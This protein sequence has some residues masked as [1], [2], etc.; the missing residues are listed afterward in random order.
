MKTV[1]ALALLGA[2]LAPAKN[3]ARP[4]WTLAQAKAVLTQSAFSVT[5]ETQ[6][7]RPE[8]GLTFN[9]HALV[10]C[11]SSA[12][13]VF[14]GSAH[15]AF[16]DSDVPRALHV[17]PPGPHHAFPWT[18]RGH[19][20]A[21]VPD[22]RR[23]LLRVVS[24]GV[25]PRSGPS[26]QPAST[27]RSTTTATPTRGRARAHRR[28]ALCAARCRHLLVVGARRLSA[29]GRSASALPRRSADDAVSLGDLLRARGLREPERR[30][31]PL[32]SRVHPR[33]LRD[34]AGVP[35]G[36]RA[37][38]RLRVR[39]RR[40][41]LRLDRGALARGEHGRRVHR[42]QGVRRFSHLRRAAG[43]LAPVLGRACPS[44]TSLRTRS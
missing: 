25:V 1:A 24:G 11:G 30:E 12:G 13:F 17:R 39:R 35:E 28:D 3:G 42:P 32:R 4:K 2:F 37:L 7:D 29:D 31:D 22:P 6:P 21:F 26:L 33:P 38:R 14:T 10:P 23:L 15:D 18:A 34:A 36:R 16:T 40:R 9:A 27:R 43:R 5:D 41:R 19:V 44:T 8:Y 20:A